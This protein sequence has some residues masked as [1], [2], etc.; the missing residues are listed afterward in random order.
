MKVRSLLALAALRAANAC[1]ADLAPLLAGEYDYV[2]DTT[3]PWLHF[4]KATDEWAAATPP[5]G[6]GCHEYRAIAGL[7][8]DGCTVAASCDVC[9]DPDG[10][11][12]S[13]VFLQGGTC[14]DCSEFHTT[15]LLM[16]NAKK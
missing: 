9:A 15:A 4:L 6:T 2:C 13:Q 12:V 16:Q 11:I 8:P 10:T 7:P 1:S 3:V 14:N 5:D